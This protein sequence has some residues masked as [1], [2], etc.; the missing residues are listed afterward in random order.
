[1]CSSLMFFVMLMAQMMSSGEAHDGEV[2]NPSNVQARRATLRGVGAEDGAAGLG[3]W[4]TLLSGLVVPIYRPGWDFEV[5]IDYAVQSSLWSLGRSLSFLLCKAAITVLYG[6]ELDDVSTLLVTGFFF[7]AGQPI[8]VVFIKLPVVFWAGLVCC[9]RSHLTPAADLICRFETVLFGNF[10]ISIG[11]SASCAV[12]ICSA[13]KVVSFWRRGL[14]IGV[15][16]RF[17]RSRLRLTW[18]VCFSVWSR[19]AHFLGEFYAGLVE[20]LIPVSQGGTSTAIQWYAI[21]SKPNYL[22]GGCG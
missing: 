21:E 3:L 5:V 12:L 17:C 13:C 19:L 6:Y 9:G 18:A 4:S 8:V 11:V 22:L 10:A 2:G 15:N 16:V 1:M 20:D 14:N 7:V